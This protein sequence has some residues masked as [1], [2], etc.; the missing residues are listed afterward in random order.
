MTNAPATGGTTSVDSQ[1]TRATVCEHVNDAVAK[2][3]ITS[4]AIEVLPPLGL[5]I[6]LFC[7]KSHLNVV[8][9]GPAQ[10]YSLSP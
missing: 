5:A 2:P 3:N 8:L 9:E 1:V 10:G 7:C 6:L 4:A